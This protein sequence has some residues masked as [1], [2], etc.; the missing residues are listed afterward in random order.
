[1]LRDRFAAYAL[2]I[3]KRPHRERAPGSR[4]AVA[5]ARDK[6][7]ARVNW[8]MSALLICAYVQ[9]STIRLIFAISPL[10]RSTSAYYLI[11]TL[12]FER[13]W[14]IR[15]SSLCCSPPTRCATTAPSLVPIRVWRLLPINHRCRNLHP[16]LCPNRT[17]S[18]TGHILPIPDRAPVHYQPKATTP[19][20]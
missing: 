9:A 6:R 10:T 11:R 12:P 20:C 7:L 17:G 3:S 2:D 16:H 4:Q 1:M 19:T 13:C 15:S 14:P 5:T 8:Y 18:L